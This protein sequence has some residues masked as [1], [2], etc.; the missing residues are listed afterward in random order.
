[1]N[2]V[3]EIAKVTGI[4]GIAVWVFA[5]ILREIIKSG[6]LKALSRSQITELL[7]LIII[8]AG[9]ITF[10]AIGAWVFATVWVNTHTTRENGRVFAQTFKFANFE[11][12]KLKKMIETATGLKYDFSDMVTYSI[13]LAHT[14]NLR[15]ASHEGNYLFD[16]GV[17][18]VL[19]NE[20]PCCEINKLKL[21]S[22]SDNPGNPKG[23][24][25]SEIKKEL[26][27]KL[28]ENRELVV[29]RIVECLKNED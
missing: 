25:E 26:K 23:L 4:A 12:D 3:I 22:W 5:I 2:T 28:K 16:G 6:L 10:F 9:A 18:V 20:S 7:K 21:K 1:V 27:Q 15:P 19:V 14:G 24:L 29:Q 17:V 13:R 8:S 11:D